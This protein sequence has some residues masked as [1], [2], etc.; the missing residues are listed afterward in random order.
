[1]STFGAALLIF[2]GCP[3]DTGAFNGWIVLGVMAA[4]VAGVFITCE[5]A[6][7]RS[8]F[9]KRPPS[10]ALRCPRCGRNTMPNANLCA[11]CGARLGM[12]RGNGT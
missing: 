4:I 1:M 8:S 12:Y 10:P 9:R 3:E 6:C 5:L 2:E 7:K 11:Y